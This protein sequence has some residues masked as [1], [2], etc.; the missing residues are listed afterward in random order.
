[1][2]GTVMGGGFLL[3]LCQEFFMSMSSFP[4]LSLPVVPAPGC[5]QTNKRK[6][7]GFS[8]IEVS[9]V[10]AIVL[11]LAIIAI[12]AV[13]GY[14]VENKVPK[15]GAELARFVLQ[16]QINSQPGSTAP[17][18]DI[19]TASLANMVA[20]SSVFSTNES[21][22]DTLVLH[23]LG[24]GG[25]ITVTTVSG[26]E[27]FVITMNKVSH[28][29]CPG[30]ASVMQRISQSITIAGAGSSAQTVKDVDNDIEYNALQ[31]EGHCAK[32]DVNTFA[33]TAS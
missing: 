24:S 8:L 12:P 31:A 6:Q 22:G 32:G 23:G 33:F 26:G 30:L 5:S 28:A 18:A 21:N 11:L 29:A 16:T 1:M 13:G 19:S 25:A 10:T 27:K 20:E 9:I 2:A 15:V 3:S 7:A 17:Y 4:V 14:V